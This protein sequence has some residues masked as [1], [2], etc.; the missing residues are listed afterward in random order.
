MSNLNFSDIIGVQEKAFKVI[1]SNIDTSISREISLDT[2][3]SSVGFSSTSFIRLVIALEA[4]FN[5]EFDGDKMFFTA[6]STVKSMV[7]YV[8][9]KII[10][11]N[12][13]SV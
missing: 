10:N 13:D 5:F 9:S 12:C 1:M 3:L 8:E 2:D 7:E 4:E 11:K 6:F